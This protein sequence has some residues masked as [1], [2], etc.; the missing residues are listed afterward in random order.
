MLVF[1]CRLKPPPRLFGGG[2][3]KEKKRRMEKASWYD[4]DQALV[5][6]KPVIR[7][8]AEKQQLASPNNRLQGRAAMELSL[9]AACEEEE[10][11]HCLTPAVK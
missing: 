2:G 7:R 9:R 3:K 6:A 8:W 4:R 5:R 11:Q 1:Q 10:Q